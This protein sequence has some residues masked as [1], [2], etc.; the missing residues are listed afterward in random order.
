MTFICKADSDGE[1]TDDVSC[2]RPLPATVEIHRR[3]REVA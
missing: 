2:I 3:G 1:W